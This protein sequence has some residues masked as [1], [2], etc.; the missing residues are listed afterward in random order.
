MLLLQFQS[1]M[2]MT[3]LNTHDHSSKRLEQNINNDL[4][5]LSLWT[6]LN[7]LTLNSSKSHSSKSHS[8]KSHA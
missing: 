4:A 6:K 2:R 5:K 3:C 7:E 1:C 8:S